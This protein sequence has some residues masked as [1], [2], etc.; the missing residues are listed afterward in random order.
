MYH[1][2]FVMA[3]CY[4]M[5]S[6]DQIVSV[7]GLPHRG[8]WLI[9][10]VDGYASALVIDNGLHDDCPTL[11]EVKFFGIEGLEQSIKYLAATVFGFP[12]FYLDTLEYKSV[13]SK[14]IVDGEKY[15]I[16]Y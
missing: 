14:F 5:L 11:H 10:G 13:E 3:K 16:L 7:C 4:V 9:E 2:Q 15:V 8:T 6:Y 12:Y 1:P